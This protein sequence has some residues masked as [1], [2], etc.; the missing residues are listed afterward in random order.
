MP[1]EIF[2]VCRHS[3]YADRSIAQQERSG[4]RV[5]L[6]ALV[7]AL[8]CRRGCLPGRWHRRLCRP[9]PSAR[10]NSAAERVHRGEYNEKGS[11]LTSEGS[12]NHRSRAPLNGSATTCSWLRQ[13][14]PLRPRR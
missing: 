9:C 5:P 1:I 10:E 4:E 7:C 11:H 3:S 8:V 13:R 12:A 14:F 2:K 6:G